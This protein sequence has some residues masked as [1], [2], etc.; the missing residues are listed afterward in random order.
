MDLDGPSFLCESLSGSRAG[1]SAAPLAAL[2]WPWGRLSDR[3]AFL[4]FECEGFKASPSNSGSRFRFGW[5]LMWRLPPYLSAVLITLLHLIL[6]ASSAVF[7]FC[8]CFFRLCAVA[9]SLSWRFFCS[10]ILSGV[11]SSGVLL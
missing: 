2:C 7:S 9:T 4:L 8:F 10:M 6:S 1:L 5:L 3:V 11:V